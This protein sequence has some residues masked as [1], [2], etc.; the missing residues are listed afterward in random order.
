MDNQI[1]KKQYY[2]KKLHREILT[3]MDE[4]DRICKEYHLHYYLM[5]GS[6]LGAVRHKGF[7]PWDDDLDITMPRDD[8]NKFVSLVS[9]ETECKRVLN[10]RFYFRWITTEKDY[11]QDFAKVCIKGTVFKTHNG[12]ADEN[13]G[14]YVDVFPLDPC[15]AYSKKIQRKSIMYRHFHSTLVLK[16]AEADHMDWKMKHWPRN[17]ISK[18]ITSRAI[19]R[20]MLYI[21]RP[22]KDVQTD[23][24]AFFCT[25]YP[26]KRQVFPNSWHGEGKRVQFEDRTYICPTEAEKMMQLIYGDDYM[27]LPPENKRKTHYPIRVVFSDGEEILFD[28]PKTRVSYKDLLD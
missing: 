16:G 25:P 3:I 10:E 28:K 19:Y 13:A 7:I 23:H 1:E 9:N 8:F 5:C 2:L 4:I 20:I 24:Q 21:I 17:L 18:Y 26:I 12:K 6:C 14:I 15:E 11:S 27:E 22:P